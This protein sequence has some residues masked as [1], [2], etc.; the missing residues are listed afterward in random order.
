MHQRL[1]S[2]SFAAALSFASFSGL[3]IAPP[4]P[5]PSCY[6]SA[7]L[8]QLPAYQH[9]LTHHFIVHVKAPESLSRGRMHG[10]H[11]RQLA[12]QNAQLQS[13]ANHAGH[14]PPSRTDRKLR[15]LKELRTGTCHFAPFGP[16]RSRER[17]LFLFL[18]HVNVFESQLEAHSTRRVHG[19]LRHVIANGSALFQSRFN[20]F[21]H[22]RPSS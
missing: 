12:N 5:Y 3:S 21:D 11:R 22:F 15:L 18:A 6:H 1:W 2:P 20:R 17:D 9:R 14:S 4:I 13:H 8:F 16:T 10:V 19:V 7:T